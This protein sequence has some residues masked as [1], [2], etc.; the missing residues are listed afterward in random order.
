LVPRPHLIARLDG[1]LRPGC[2][3]TL[4]SAPAGY[5]KTTLLSSWI[6]HGEPDM[7]VA[8]VSLAEGDNDPASFWAYATTALQTIQAG[9]GEIVHAAFESPHPMPIKSAL[10]QLVNQVAQV[11]D[12]IVLVLDDYHAISTPAIHSALSFLLENMP[13]QMHLVLATRADPPLPIPR[14][15]ARGQLVELYESDLRFTSQEATEFLRQVMGLS[16]S[17][18]D[19]VALE[20]RTEGWIAGLQMAAI[21]MHGRDDIAAFVRAFAGSN[22]YI[23]DYLGEEV[24]R[25]QPTDVQAFLLQTAILERLS[26]ELCNAVIGGGE[27]V[28]ADS[29]ADSQSMLE[30]LERSNLFVVPMDDERHWY[31]YHHLFA[32][33]LRQRLQREKPELVPE[34]HRRASEWHEQN[35]RIAEAVGHALAAFDYEQAAHLI[36]RVGWEMLVRGACSILLG[37]IDAFPDGFVRSRPRLG[38]IRAW[39]L[40]VTGQIDRAESYLSN[41]D[42]QQ[43]QGEAAAVRAYATSV[44]G[45]ARHGIAFAQQALGH[46]PEDN[47][48]LRGFLALNL[49]IAY[50]SSGEPIAASHALDQAIELSR[51][52]DQIDLTL[53][54]TATLGHVQDNQ[55]MLRQAIETHRRVLDLARDLGGQPAPVVGMA[56][57][58][59]AEVLYEWNDLDGT[60]CH[61]TEGLKLLELGHF[62]TYL[63]FGHSLRARV[64]L[65]RGDLDD[66]QTAIQQAE[67]LAQGDDFAYMMAV[68]GGLRARLNLAQGNAAAA[69]RW[70]QAHRWTEGTEIDRVCEAEQ[71]AVAWVLVA[72]DRAGEAMHMLAPLLE[73]AQTAG[74]M[75]NAIKILTLQALAFQAQNNQDGALSALQQALSLAEPEG[76][77][78]TFVDEG[79]PMAR[80][81]SQLLVVQRKGRCAPSPG[82]APN[83]VA[84]LLAA[85]GQEVELPS[86]AMESLV[87]PLS[88]R[89]LEVLRL[90]VAGLSNSEIADELVIALSTV[91]SHINRIY[92]KLGVENRT[93]AVIK[94]QDLALI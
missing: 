12:P 29:F 3:L 85:F 52:S 73:A 64:C 79:K 20:R 35:G 39:C 60:L 21:S 6:A 37:W 84:R 4:V 14:L 68:L 40:V 26:G 48:S 88:A 1:G 13:P 82:I 10:T 17:T 31:R 56:Y 42:V 77:V 49:G 46:L 59:I 86:P 16:L 36:E 58:G 83:Y 69:A 66:A 78:R 8:W 44:R 33:L 63:L 54:A 5:G 81:L 75:E 62:V 91:K 50:S 53:A 51:L 41:V 93:Q 23:L 15:R 34:L 90:V 32:D 74:R 55:A 11:S 38:V 43:V 80:L 94:T 57:L 25:Q 19:V 71:M 47:L 61:V 18:E 9:I 72:Q 76:Y 28:E 30:Y 65:A 22:R 27:R 92:G 45:D 89:E 24:L 70:A 2:R 87:E 7:H 67:R